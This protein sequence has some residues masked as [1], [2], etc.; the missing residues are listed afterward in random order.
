VKKLWTVEVSSEVVVLAET[1]DE[2]EKEARKLSGLD[3][4]D[5]EY[6]AREMTSIPCGWEGDC[7]PY[8]Y[9]VEKTIDECIAEG[10]AP[11]LRRT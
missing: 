4:G 3:T 11:C 7:V 8:G 5:S 2:A 1:R 6:T 10:L 9:D